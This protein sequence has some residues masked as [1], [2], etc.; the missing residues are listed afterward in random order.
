MPSAT[1]DLNISAIDLEKY[2]R[3]QVQNILVTSDQGL[4][5]KFP[6]NLLQPHVSHFGVKGR[7]ILEYEQQGKAISLKRYE[8]F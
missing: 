5:V 4:K 6:A 7:F 3:G 2:Y 1:F 8:S